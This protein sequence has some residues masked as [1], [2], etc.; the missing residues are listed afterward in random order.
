MK[1]DKLKRITSDREWSNKSEPLK[2]FEGRL[3]NM[4]LLIG[5]SLQSDLP[6]LA[7][8]EA[9]KQYIVMLVAC[10]E[11]YLREMFKVIIDK[12]LVPLEKILELKK[13]KEVKFT[14]EELEYI[15]Y[16]NISLSE[17]SAEYI[18]FQNFEEI[19]KV[20]SIVNFKLEMKKRL[21]N[22]S[23]IVP[24]PEEI[25]KVKKIDNQNFITEFFKQFSLHKK[26]TNEEF[27]YHKIELL[28]ELRH[29]IIHKNIDIDIGQGDILDMTLAIYE[30]IMTL[31]N[32]VEYLEKSNLSSP[33]SKS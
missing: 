28:L 1:M 24:S 7:K 22:K 19:M 27:I 30:F 6:S 31:E 8:I 23:D 25:S 29:K 21:E 13:L 9:R 5:A 33:P 11:T 16:M 32:I 15:K 18:N 4:A 12:K 2:V 3:N 14:L 20:F 26:A 10:Y 17:L